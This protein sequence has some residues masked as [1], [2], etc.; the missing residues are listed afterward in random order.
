MSKFEVSSSD[1]RASAIVL[2]LEPVVAP[3][4]ALHDDQLVN[5]R[6][7]LTKSP[8]SSPFTYTITP[9]L[10][11]H[12]HCNSHPA[13]LLT[14]DV[15]LVPKTSTQPI[16]V[17]NLT[18]VF[19]RSKTQQ[20]ISVIAYSPGRPVLKLE[21]TTELQTKKVANEISG[22]GEIYGVHGGAK[23]TSTNKIE[24][25]KQY[26]G[27]IE[28]WA[29]ASED[30]GDNPNS[31]RW[32]L[33][34]NKSQSWTAPGDLTIAILL[35]RPAEIF[36]CRWSVK[37]EVDWSQNAKD[38][39]AAFKIW[40]KKVP[41]YK[42]YPSEDVTPAKDIPYWIDSAHLEKLLVEGVLL[43]RMWNVRLPVNYNAVE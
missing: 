40:E 9:G 10:E 21:R 34:G 30:N 3:S 15:R 16:H 6:N 5:L 24:K 31:A 36:L 26:A 39:L 23:H 29:V 7:F 38:K 41:H 11:I 8:K 37:V 19:E 14:Y 33:E 18:V 42:K 13:S 4:L 20:D 2:D 22:G 32:R 27:L 12:G 43:R 17:A 1:A 35:M 25:E 28:A